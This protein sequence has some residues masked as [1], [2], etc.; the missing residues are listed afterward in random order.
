MCLQARMPPEA[1]VGH[2]ALSRS[3]RATTSPAKSWRLPFTWNPC[4]TAC[5]TK[6]AAILHREILQLALVLLGQST[7]LLN[8]RQEAP[9]PE[10]DGNKYILWQHQV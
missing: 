6:P 4:D 9:L 10:M 1:H 8:L 3:I 5:G 2:A 7:G